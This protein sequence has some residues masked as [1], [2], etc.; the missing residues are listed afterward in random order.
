MASVIK[1]FSTKGIVGAFST[2]PFTLFSIN[3]SG[4]SG[5]N[6]NYFFRVFVTAYDPRTC[7]TY[8]SDLIYGRVRYIDVGEV[9][10]FVEAEVGVGGFTMSYTISFTNPNVILSISHDI[11]DDVDVE[12]SLQGVANGLI[13]T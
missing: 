4:V 2:V 12:V 8:R 9:A 7:E 3:E 1:N 10:S 13:L 5:N 6:K 11:T